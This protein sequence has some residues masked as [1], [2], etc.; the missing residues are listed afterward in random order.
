MSQRLIRDIA[1]SLWQFSLYELTAEQARILRFIIKISFLLCSILF[2]IFLLFTPLLPMFPFPGADGKVSTSFVIF[3]SPLAGAT[4][5]VSYGAD[6]H[7]YWWILIVNTYVLGIGGE[8]FLGL[9]DVWTYEKLYRKPYPWEDVVIYKLGAVLIVV[10]S[11]F[12]F[13][14]N[15]AH[16]LVTVLTAAFSAAARAG[17]ALGLRLQLPFVW[18]VALALVLDDLLFYIGHRLSHNVRFMWKLGHINHHRTPRLTRL[19]AA[20]DFQLWFLNGS[21]GSFVTQVIGHAFFIVLIGEVRPEQAAAGAILTSVIRF[22]SAS[23]AHSLA[24]YVLFS[25]SRWLAALENVFVIGRVHY[26]H[27][28]SLP[29]HDRARGCNF[30]AT[31]SFWDKLFGTYVRAPKDVPPTGLFHEEDLPG[32]PWKF[33]YA[34]WLTLLLELFR[35]P[36]RL[37]P[38]I[39]FGSPD[40][41]PPVP[42]TLPP[43]RRDADQDR[44]AA[45]GA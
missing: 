11:V 33:A 34:E 6:A 12:I 9:L 16:V 8:V 5:S 23:T 30:A 17:Q 14:P 29:E 35:N 15:A 27:H 21:R 42:G 45:T 40:Y 20:P 18:I 24:C 39:L 44:A 4:P 41:T 7:A 10:A 3:S 22:M 37:W 36:L 28:S 19:T 2:V 31:F 25:R 26:V 43:R 13:F 32:N 38:R 1:L